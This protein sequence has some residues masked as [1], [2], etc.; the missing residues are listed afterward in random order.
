VGDLSP[1]ERTGIAI[2]RALQ[3]WPGAAKVI[4]LDE[5]TATMPAA[6]ASRLFEVVR[7]IRAQGLAVLYVTHHLD[8]VL[9]LGDSVTV[10]R[11]GREI[12]T[13]PVGG[14]IHQE[15]VELMLGHAMQS[16]SPVLSAEVRESDEPVLR[17]SS[18]SA[19]TVTDVSVVV[20]RGEIVGVAGITGSGCDELLQAIVG[21]IPRSG[22]VEIDGKPVPANR[23]HLAVRAGLAYVPAD[24]QRNS[25]IPSVDVRSN[26]TASG[27][28]EFVHRGLLSGKAEQQEV[29]RWINLLAVRPNDPDAP[30]T[31][32]SGGNQQKVVMARWLRRSPKI[33]V[34][35]EPTQGVDIEA[36]E[37]IYAALRSTLQTGGVLLSS[38][39]SDELAALCDRVVILRRGQLVT[40]LSGSEITA[41]NI[42]SA[43]LAGSA[44]AA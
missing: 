25:I 18:L 32:L 44:D 4:V 36:R 23:P 39:D 40:E 21:D 29:Q 10:L 2:G 12:A 19:Q 9:E 6:E 26:V 16:H 34:L 33:M 43:C 42:E 30:V 41:E 3:D 13:R 1:V 15:L 14:L 31:S 7:R 20:G 37:S 22:S 5:P 38:S 24:R 11:D 27:V 17:V 8:E 35:I 28:K